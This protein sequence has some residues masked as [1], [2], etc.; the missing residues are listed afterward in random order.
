[1]NR[2]RLRS[3]RTFALTVFAIGV[4]HLQAQITRDWVATNNG[5]GDFNDRYTCGVRDGAGNLF[6]GGSVTNS[7]QDRDYLIVKLN[8]SGTLVWKN[9]LNGE[10]NGSDEVTAITLDGSGNVVVTGLS[11]SL[12]N[13]TDYRTVKYDGNSVMLWSTSYNNPVA[14]G[15]DQA[16][17]VVVDGLGNVI[18][19]GQ[20]DGDPGSAEFDDYATV[21]YNAQGVEQW[22]TRFDGVGNATDR[23][24]GLD[25]DGNGNLYVTGR[26]DNGINDDYV[27][28][29]YNGSG[30]QQWIQYGDRGGRDRAVA[31]VLDGSANVYVTGRSDNGNNDDMWTVK[32]NN[33]GNEQ[34]Q[35][36]YDFVEDDRAIA[37]AIDA[38]ANVYVTGQSDNDATPFINYDVATVAYSTG[39]A[40]LWAQRYNGSASNDDLPASIATDG[41]HV[42]VCGITDAD[43]SAA[44]QNDAITRSY[45]ATNGGL[46]WSTISAG[47][48]GSDDEARAVLPIPTGCLLLGSYNVSA[49]DR[50][51]SAIVYSVSGAQESQQ[52]VTGIGDNNENVRAITSDA[53]GNIY[54]AGYTVA[55]R[56]NRNMA[57]WKFTST[58]TLA[59]TNTFNGTSPASPDEAQGI[60]LTNAN[61]PVLAGFSKNSGESNNITCFRS[62]PNTCDSAWTRMV[63]TP[64]N[65]SDKVYDL[66][67]DAAGNF[68][69]TGRIDSDPSFAPDDDA[70]TAKLNAAGTILWNVSYNSG[71]GREDRGSFV[72]VAPS[73]N[74]YIT[75]RTWNGSDFDVLTIKYTGSGTQQWVRTYDGGNGN[76]EPAGLAIDA[77]ENIIIAASA[78]VAGDT[79]YD[80]I[81][82]KYDNGGT[83]QWATLYNSSGDD[84]AAALAVDTDGNAFVAATSDVDP[85][86]A[87][88]LQMMVVKFNTSGSQ[89]W[90][91]PFGATADDHADDIVVNDLGQVCVT[92][93]TNSGSIADPNYNATT[94]IFSPNGDALWTDTYNAPGDTSDVPARIQL[95]SDGFIIGGYTS[96][97]ATMRDVMV[98]KY[99]GTVAGIREEQGTAGAVYPSPFNEH[100]IVSAATNGRIELC[101]A[102]G[103][104][105]L[106]QRTV[107]GQNTI[108][109]AALADGLY[110]YK[111]F[112]GEH[113]STTGRI[114]HQH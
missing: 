59:C 73:G 85:S 76:D 28:L 56:E 113:S 9:E 86:N 110:T 8:A 23:A 108:Q 92:G 82:L 3:F 49:N 62:Y 72:R 101:D 44:I 111:L 14:N 104:L 13:G 30:T 53:S 83:Q 12:S 98:I 95:T 68:F 61:E 5:T 63:I 25:V 79:T 70:W 27:T 103:R 55:S 64:A 60:S 21:K 6:L 41:V 87:Q 17:A 29:K 80:V 75:G 99:T 46:E 50:N 19:T 90:A 89:Q 39:G 97:T 26:S 10:G 1:M 81:A 91:Q 102:T 58:G 94:V 93:H 42:Y 47:P 36:S 4:V 2:A 54:A 35:M 69:M 109:T 40:Q 74:V 100:L 18:V 112:G 22:V 45:T 11:K 107:A 33:A 65:G 78:Q 31:L 16:N 114:V 15:Y 7:D 43:A 77:N 84:Q 34:W 88:D 37:M 32:Y 71:A 51:A 48:G 52:T 106:Q 105:V 20:S 96:T 24:T 67:R 38:A 66:V 57:L